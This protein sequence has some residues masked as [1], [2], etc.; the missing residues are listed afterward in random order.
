MEGNITSNVEAFSQGIK[1][2]VSFLGIG[3]AEEN[4]FDSLGVKFGSMVEMDEGSTAKNFKG[5]S[6]FQ[7]REA[8]MMLEDLQRG[9]EGQRFARHSIDKESSH[10]NS[11]GPIETW[12]MTTKQKSPSSLEK[13]PI[14]PLSNTILL[15]TVG[16]GTFMGD[17]LFFQEMR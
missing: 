4:A 16:T 5:K 1:T 17:T 14:F 6:I 3:W 8:E 9:L 13:V 12:N 2:F 10:K 7:V 11:I 15:G